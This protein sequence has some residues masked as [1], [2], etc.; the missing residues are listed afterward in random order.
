MLLKHALHASA[1]MEP[2]SCTSMATSTSSSLTT[3]ERCP[4]SIRY[5]H[6]N[7][8]LPRL[9]PPWRNWLLSMAYQSHSAVTMAPQ[10][11]SALFAEFATDWIFD[12]GTSAPTNPHS[13]GQAESAVKIIKGLL[14][15]LKYSGQD[16]YLTLLAYCST[17]WMHICACLVRCSTS[18]HCSQWY[19]SISAIP[20]HTL[21][22]TVAI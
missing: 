3:A 20:T 11:A 6:P 4:S 21:L 22:P 7:A 9:Y 18:M 5:L 19:H 1:T 2:T 8:M 15:W 16:L 17:P 14:T 13:N 10:F 12:H